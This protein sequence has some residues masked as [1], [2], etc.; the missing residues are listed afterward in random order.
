MYDIRMIVMYMWTLGQL[1][2][3]DVCADTFIPEDPQQQ[4]A[5]PQHRAEQPPLIR[6]AF[7]QLSVGGPGDVFARVVE[8]V[9]HV[10]Q[11][12][13]P[14]DAG[15][16]LLKRWKLKG[17]YFWTANRLISANGHVFVIGAT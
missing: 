2:G 9:R 5:P 11:H 10:R 12:R 15:V 4:G 6:P 17:G 13:Y 1:S 7:D 14:A 8:L 3:L 16:L